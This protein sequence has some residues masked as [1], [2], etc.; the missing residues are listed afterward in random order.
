MRFL[1]ILLFV[2][3]V[4]GWVI[5]PELQANDKI[6][7]DVRFALNALVSGRQRISSG[8]FKAI[9]W[10]WTGAMED[11]EFAS[12]DIYCAFD[13][14]NDKFR[15]DRNGKVRVTEF[16]GSDG[17]DRSE[18]VTY[19]D[20]IH[21]KY[22]RLEG[23][24]I[25]WTSEDEH[26]VDVMPR[27]SVLRTARPFCFDSIGLATSGD[28][29]DFPEMAKLI[30]VFSKQGP[31]SGDVAD[32]KQV[33]LEWTFADGLLQRRLWL[34]PLKEYAPT[35]LEVLAKVEMDGV[36]KFSRIVDIHTAWIRINEVWV[37]NRSTHVEN[38][39]GQDMKTYEVELSWLRVNEDLQDDIFSAHGFGLSKFARVVD[40]RAD[41][42]V[43]LNKIGLNGINAAP[44]QNPVIGDGEKDGWSLFMWLN[45]IAVAAIMVVLCA[46]IASRH[47]GG[48]GQ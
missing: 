32:G 1:I 15:F 30:A 9:E 26:Q 44:I 46:R 20:E 31:R 10:Y 17:R 43:V 47:R 45:V 36:I 48:N 3:S 13:S 18:A 23:K 37:P 7:N 12:T 21:S 11:K 25:H 24:S 33:L 38:R 4:C 27:G 22:I 14:A 41:I 2:V 40:N 35:R 6:V 16:S 28:L 42:P 5:V 39:N 34:D 19:I 29:L 8:E